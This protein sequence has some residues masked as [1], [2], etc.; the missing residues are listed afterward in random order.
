MARSARISGIALWLF[1]LLFFPAAG[2]ACEAH[3]DSGRQLFTVPCISI[4]NQ[5]ER[6]SANFKQNEQTFTLADSW[7]SGLRDAYITDIQVLTTPYPVAI[8]FFGLADG[9]TAEYQPASK[10]DLD[11]AKRSI[12]ISIK[13]YRI[14]P[15]NA[16]CVQMIVNSAK[17]FPLNLGY[18]S[19][20]NNTYTITAQNISK[21]IT[22]PAPV[23][24]Q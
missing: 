5:A 8:V 3:Y 21:T 20:G 12:T 10:A 6:Y 16:A 17:A 24:G 9:C 7:P 4:D 1:S 2:S 22:L 19:D 23:I 14:A 15:A 18:S 11:F 13:T